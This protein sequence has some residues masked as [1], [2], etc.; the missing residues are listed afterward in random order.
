MEKP[1]AG[2][3][4]LDDTVPLTAQIEASQ[5]LHSHTVSGA[6]RAAGAGGSGRG[7]GREWREPVTGGAGGCPGSTGSAGTQRERGWAGACAEPA[8]AG[9][10][11]AGGGLR[12]GSAGWAG[13]EG[14]RCGRQWGRDL[15][16]RVAAPRSPSV[17]CGGASAWSRGSFGSFTP[18][19]SAGF[20]GAASNTLREGPL[21]VCGG[22]RCGVLAVSRPPR[23]RPCEFL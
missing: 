2:K 3:V 11:V 4:L 19:L 15:A 17:R 13:G 23:A 10:G 16:A 1:L 21:G 6:G 18:S 5:S 12:R 14:E 9:L 7:G 8:A 20:P 22:G